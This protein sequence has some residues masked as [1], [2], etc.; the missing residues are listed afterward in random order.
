[1]SVSATIKVMQ[2]VVSADE[3]MYSLK[4]KRAV[5]AMVENGGVVSTAMIKAGYSPATAR[6]PHKLTNTEGFKE[7]LIEYGL[8][9]GLVTRALVAD[10][11]K[12]PGRRVKELALAAD[13]LKMRSRN[14]ESGD[15]FNTLIFNGLQATTIARRVLADNTESAGTP[16]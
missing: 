2:D 16:D 8:T 14:E 10:I 15:T 13:I 7:L 6:S 5:E 12:K 4:Q 3:D 9:E 11:K 1:M